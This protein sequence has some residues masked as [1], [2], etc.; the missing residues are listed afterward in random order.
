[1]AKINLEKVENF[2]LRKVTVNPP[3]FTMHFTTN[4]PQNHHPEHHVFPKTPCKNTYP[5]RWKKFSK[6]HVQGS[7][8]HRPTGRMYRGK[9]KQCH[10]Y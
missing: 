7:P 6:T 4:S 3:A 10:Q 5:P 9:L 8:Y 1:V 2:R